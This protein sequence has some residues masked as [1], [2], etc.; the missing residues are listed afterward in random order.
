MLRFLDLYLLLWVTPCTLHGQ[1]PPSHQNLACGLVVDPPPPATVIITVAAS[2][3][4]IEE[5]LLILYFEMLTMGIKQ[6]R[7]Y[8]IYS[9]EKGSIAVTM[10]IKCNK[11]LLFYKEWM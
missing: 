4:Y 11:A 1:T 6:S 10:G 2:K 7:L 3:S 8:L 9:I 5:G